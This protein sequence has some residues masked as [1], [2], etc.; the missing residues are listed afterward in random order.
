MKI[1]KKLKLLNFTF[2]VVGMILFLI[3]G[4]YMDI[5]YDYLKGMEDGPRMLFRSAHIYFLL[6]SI[7]NLCI[8]VYWEVRNDKLIFIK[9]IISLIAIISPIFL[10]FGFFYEPFMEA[11]SRPYSTMGLYA[12]FGLGILLLIIK[13]I[14]SKLF[15]FKSL[16]AEEN[17]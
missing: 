3:Q 17:N 5:N 11:L 15:S 10:L 9:N 13:L 8:G 7:I 2:G 6:A 12:L 14:E 4:Q 16:K 1:A